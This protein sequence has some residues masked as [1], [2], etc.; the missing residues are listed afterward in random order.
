VKIADKKGNTMIPNQEGQWLR[1]NTKNVPE[2]WVQCTETKKV[3][4]KYVTSKS[5]IM[6]GTVTGRG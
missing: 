5:F 1:I 2:V 3:K 6:R 4:D